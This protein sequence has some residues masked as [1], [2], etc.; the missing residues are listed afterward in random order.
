MYDSKTVIL[1]IRI[2]FTS[3]ITE[4]FTAKIALIKNPL[5]QNYLFF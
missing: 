3:K 5:K 1:E 4:K 2:Y